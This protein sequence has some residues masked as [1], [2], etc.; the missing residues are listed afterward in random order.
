MN[1]VLRHIWA[2]HAFRLIGLASMTAFALTRNEDPIN[3]NSMIPIYLAHIINRHR[4]GFGPRLP[5]I[6]HSN[7]NRQQRAL[8]LVIVIDRAGLSMRVT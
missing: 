3:N 2:Q 1:V 4:I 8:I 7:H 5:P 6:H